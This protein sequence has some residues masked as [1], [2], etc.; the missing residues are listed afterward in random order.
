[1]LFWKEYRALGIFKTLHPN[2]RMNLLQMSNGSKFLFFRKDKTMKQMVKN[3]Q[4]NLKK[5]YKCWLNEYDNPKVQLSL[6]LGKFRNLSST[7]SQ[8][9]VRIHS[10]RPIYSFTPVA[11]WPCFGVHFGKSSVV[12]VDF[13]SL[14]FL[15]F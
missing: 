3:E 12:S 7:L 1:M 6:F 11:L 13:L 2:Y 10:Y 8:K 15:L 5:K 14:Q 9:V 4:P